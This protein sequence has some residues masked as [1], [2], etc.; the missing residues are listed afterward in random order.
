MIH[1][2][3]IKDFV[4]F[5]LAIIVACAWTFYAYFKL[6]NVSSQIFLTEWVFVLCI[7]AQS[8]DV[9]TT[10]MVTLL[11]RDTGI[12]LGK[13]FYLFPTPLPFLEAL[14][15]S[16][17]FGLT[18]MTERY[19]SPEVKR[20]ES[21]YN[22]QRD[23]MIGMRNYNVSFDSQGRTIFYNTGA[24]I[25]NL[26][27]P[28]PNEVRVKYYKIYSFLLV[29]FFIIAVPSKILASFDTFSGYTFIYSKPGQCFTLPE[30]EKVKLVM[31]TKPKSLSQ[32]DDGG[33]FND[34]GLFS[35]EYIYEREINGR[36]RKQEMEES[37]WVLRPSFSKFAMNLTYHNPIKMVLPDG[38]DR[39][40]CF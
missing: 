22:H 28:D 8:K 11:H 35:I 33:Y 10:A 29:V 3:G 2:F 13:G 1:K 34:W 19:E 37:F 38:H 9:I 36:I 14:R 30:G 16:F 24:R 4:C 31:Y 26:F 15:I 40:I 7:I 27:I 6:Y 12:V 32:S 39:E 25:V 5:V 23:D 21:G 18:L 20:N 17:P